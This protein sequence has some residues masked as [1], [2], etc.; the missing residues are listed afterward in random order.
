MSEE[1]AKEIAEA[2]EAYLRD[3]KNAYRYCK[4]KGIVE[5]IA[6]VRK[7]RVP[8]NIIQAAPDEMKKR[9]LS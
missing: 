6:A 2:S 4:E 1:K 8:E 7:V 9:D 3:Q 5:A